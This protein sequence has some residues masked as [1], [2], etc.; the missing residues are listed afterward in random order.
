MIIDKWVVMTCPEGFMT[1]QTGYMGQQ[2]GVYDL[3]VW[4]YDT[5]EGGIWDDRGCYHLPK[6]FDQLSEGLYG[7]A[8]GVYDTSDGVY[9]TRGG[10]L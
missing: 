8:E 9:G 4:V 3:Y 6:E 7:A 10:Y 5:L 1:L 2:E